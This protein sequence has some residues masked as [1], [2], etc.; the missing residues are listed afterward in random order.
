[1]NGLR[2]DK[3]LFFL[4]LAKSRTLA[5]KLVEAGQV[6]IDRVRAAHPHTPVQAGQVL[7][8]AL[9]DRVR[10]LR[11]DTLPERRGPAAEAQ[12]CYSEIAAPQPID[13]RVSKL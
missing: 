12:H 9:H 4:R 2:I 5:Q 6:R 13:A 11:I 10:V 8:L 3:L 1:M 7:T